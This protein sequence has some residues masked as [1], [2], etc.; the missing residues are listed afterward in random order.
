MTTLNTH[1][2][3]AELSAAETMFA[4][5][6]DRHVRAHRMMRPPYGD[7]DVATDRLMHRLGWAQILWSVDSQ[8]ALGAPWRTVARTAIQ[9][10][11]PG[12]VILMHDGPKSTLTALRRRILPA[13]KRRRLTMVT[14]P[15]LLVVNPPGEQRLLRGPRG[16]KH[17]GEVNVSGYFADA[18][19]RR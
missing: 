2:I 19:S 5:A 4:S 8:D 10:L 14:V 18:L 16:C 17:A 15:E 7:H 9:G 6:G 1:A 11:G 3:T 13:I 12:S